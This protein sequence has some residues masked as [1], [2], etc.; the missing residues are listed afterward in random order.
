MDL[1]E[2]LERANKSKANEILE[3]IDDVFQV[4]ENERKEDGLY[5]LPDKGNVIIIGDIHGDM[6]SLSFIL[7]DAK[8]YKN[9]NDYLIF[10]GD[11]GDRGIYSPEVYF[12]ILSLKKEF[13]DR[14]ILLRGNHEFPPELPVYPHDLPARLIERYG[15]DGKKIYEK[16][17][18][19]FDYFYNGAI[20]KEK[21]IMLHGGIPTEIKSLN[22]ISY[23]HKT[24]PSN[25]YLEEILWNDPVDG[26]NSF[27]PSPR[28]AGRVWGKNVT[29]R[30]LKIIGV[31]TL[32]RSHEPCEGIE[33]RHDGK[34]LTVFSRKG[35]PYHNTCA[36]YLKID[37]SEKAKDAYELSKMA[38]KF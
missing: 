6:Q 10:L 21:Y 28:G 32:I 30:G 29:E 12:I 37:L 15:N 35:L 26:I 5:C 27:Y 36:A 8:F 9:R 38:C 4:L 18:D 3:L 1:N 11:Y 34:I 17:R 14:V 22:D 19:M 16:L 2:L 24:H 7:K 23:A 13:P 31:K 33:V 25:S 20:V